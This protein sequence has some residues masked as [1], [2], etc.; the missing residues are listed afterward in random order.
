MQRCLVAFVC[1]LLCL[2]GSLCPAGTKTWDGMYDT[3]KIELTVVYF[4]PSDRHPLSDW[5]DRVDYLCRRIEQFHAREF[6]GQSE[7]KTIVHSQPL[8]SASTTRQLRGG[9]ADAIFFRT[10]QE[11]DKSLEFARGERSAF[12]ILLVLSDINWQP[13]DDFY[14]LKPEEEKLVF[15]GQELGGQHFPG[16]RAGGSRATY[17]KD[18]GIG[19]GLVSADG[20]R[21]PYR[22]SDCV[23]Y[24]EGCGHT[25]GLP[26]PEPIDD[27]VMG[28]AQY[29]G[30]VSESFINKEQKIRLGWEPVEQPQSEQL[31]LFS[32]FRAIP[33]P[34]IPA[35]GEAA[36]LKLDWPDGAK[37]KSVR[38]R[39]QTSI[40][41]PWIE[42]GQAWDGDVPETA[43]LGVFDHETPLSYRIDAVLENG[44]TAELWGYLQIRTDSEKTLQPM[45]LSPDLIT[46]N[47][48]DMPIMQGDL[49][50]EEIDLLEKL[51]PKECWSQG[52][53]LKED[54]K[55]LSPKRFGSRIELPFSPPAEYRL[56]VIAEPLDSPN[57]LILGQRSG[58]HRFLTLFS[59]DRDESIRS[60]I[61]N[62][63]GQNVGNETTFT[64]SLF[65]QNRLSQVIVTVR[66]K[67]VVMSVDGRTIVNWAGTP[68]QL[69]LS[70]Y[71]ATPNAE[72]LFIGAYDCRYRFH[73][74]IMEPLSK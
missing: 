36:A 56:T 49:V 70:D 35:P 20:W 3:S 22:G 19:W 71:W 39:F 60:A 27:S 21:V 30:W 59:F 58:D 11:A 17:F 51:D 13:L 6:Q 72:S 26:H 46:A 62:I 63:D 48:V 44:E 67:G 18:R 52:E 43:S 14:R 74:I 37:A 45:S 64:G 42:V 50:G 41:G 34:M 65:R 31:R 73:Q 16:A 7:L 2:H 53:W 55:L 69:S 12:P 57:G 40:D 10:L 1:S 66:R 32:E 29:V 9:D 38:V 61:E 47:S 15:E 25:V 54:G 24:H 68:D 23:P 8:V 28:A 33:E 4:V 5:R